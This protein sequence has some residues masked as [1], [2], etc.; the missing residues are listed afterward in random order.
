M[1]ERKSKQTNKEIDR[2]ALV[3]SNVDEPTGLTNSVFLDIELL[4][5]NYDSWSHGAARRFG[6]ISSY[7]MCW[8]GH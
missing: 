5:L 1:K 8:V 4:T 7:R 2:H 3:N 6:S